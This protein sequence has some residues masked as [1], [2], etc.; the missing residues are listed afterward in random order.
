MAMEYLNC[1]GLEAFEMPITLAKGTGQTVSDL[2]SDVVERR[3]RLTY[4]GD[5][6]GR[7]QHSATVGSSTTRW[8]LVNPDRRPGGQQREH[9]V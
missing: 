9:P 6:E 5:E 7:P 4:V 2:S 1:S 8:L 3:V